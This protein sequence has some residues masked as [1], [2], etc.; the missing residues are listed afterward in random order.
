MARSQR[1]W[2]AS[3]PDVIT[4]GVRATAKAHRA[5][6]VEELLKESAAGQP[7]PAARIHT[8][9]CIQEQL[10]KHLDGGG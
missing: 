4:T 5:V 8:E 10:I 9:I 2:P 6:A 7:H 1:A 3:S